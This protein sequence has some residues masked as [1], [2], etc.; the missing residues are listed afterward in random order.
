[1]RQMLAMVV[2]E[3]KDDLDLHL[4]RVEFTYNNSVNAATGLAPNEVRMGRLPRLSLMVFDRT[5]DVGHQR[6]ARNQLAH[7]DLGTDRQKRANDIVRA[8]HAI[9][10]PRIN[11]RNSALA[12]ALR[13]AP[14]FTVGG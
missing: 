11:R 5:G 1:M 10:V 14:T 9:T 7:C 2:N 13:P 3:R 6:L 8:H 4:P 12:N